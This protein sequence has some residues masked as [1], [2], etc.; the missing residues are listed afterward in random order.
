[1]EVRYFEYQDEK[2][3][4]FWE[5]SLSASSFT[6]RWGRRGTNGQQKEKS[7]DS[8]ALAKKE[9]EKLVSEKLKEGY[10]EDRKSVV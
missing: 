4:K 5:I 2:S 8:E 6:T 9:Y 1:M 7:F 3:D 10:V